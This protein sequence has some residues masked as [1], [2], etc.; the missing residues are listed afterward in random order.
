MDKNDKKID[1]KASYAALA[2]KYR[3]PSYEAVNQD[4]EIEAIEETDFLLKNIRN[5]IGEKMEFCIKLLTSILQ[6]EQNI[7]DLHECKMF[8]DE[9]KK[10]I[11]SL[12]KNLM[13]YL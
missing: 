10:K 5:R 2:K 8:S 9:Q 11:Y 3:L 7:T 12:Y 6:P 13:V 1:I 4:F